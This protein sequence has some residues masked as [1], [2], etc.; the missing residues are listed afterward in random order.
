MMFVLNRIGVDVEVDVDGDAAVGVEE[1]AGLGR[2]NFFM[3]ASKIRS[4]TSR[5]QA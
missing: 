4:K 1:R 2:F 5:W 3:R